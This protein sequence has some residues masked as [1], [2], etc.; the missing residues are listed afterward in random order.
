MDMTNLHRSPPMNQSKIDSGIVNESL[1]LRFGIS[2]APNRRLWLE[3]K[4]PHKPAIS[5][6]TRFLWGQRDPLILPEWSDKLA[7]YWTNYSI[8]YADA[9]HYVHAEVPDIAARK[10]QAFFVGLSLLGA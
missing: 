9:G 3:G 1:S 7:E 10:I 5:V 8:E 4:L 2:S 6:P